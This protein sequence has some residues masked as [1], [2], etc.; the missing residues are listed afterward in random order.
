MNTIDFV[1]RRNV[2]RKRR[3]IIR[4]FFLIFFILFFVFLINFIY[5]LS[6]KNK[7]CVEI[8]KNNLVNNNYITSLVLDEIGKK[9]F[10]FISPRKISNT[11]LKNIPMF[12][13]AVV[14]KYIIPN[15]KLFVV[16]NEKKLWAK[17]LL[18]KEDSLFNKDA[19][20]ITNEGD[21]VP[22]N[23]LN[24]ELIPDKLISLHANENV[25]PDTRQLI[26]LKNTVD[27]IQKIDLLVT[28]LLI[29][30]DLDLVIYTAN[31]FLIRAGKVESSLLKKIKKL[32]ELIKVIN[33]YSLKVQYLD[34]NL[35]TS[36]ILKTYSEDTQNKNKEKKGFFGNVI[37]NR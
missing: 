1:N 14:R 34:L 3:N 8:F 4:R 7:V 21:I 6:T 19:F 13:D 25:I 30:N 9:N 32:D 15:Y 27:K 22:E 36:A 24:L 33:K 29:N 12:K 26:L 20:Y 10:F 23:Y 5:L 37:R 11:L 16:V 2:Y 28:K 18:Y 35:E 31:A 17:M